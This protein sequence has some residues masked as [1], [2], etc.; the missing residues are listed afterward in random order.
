MLCKNFRL[1]ALSYNNR[2]CVHFVLIKPPLFVCKFNICYDEQAAR[3]VKCV[4]MRFQKHCRLIC[5]EE[6]L[7]KAYT[8]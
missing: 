5:R 4:R 7:L 6:P 3:A 1:F 8:Q 2:M